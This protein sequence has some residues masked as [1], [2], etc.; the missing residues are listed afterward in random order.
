MAK[1]QHGELILL[2]FDEYSHPNHPEYI[3]GEVTLEEAQKAVSGNFG[4]DKV[5]TEI[6]HKYAFWGV[7]QNEMGEPCQ[8]LYDRDEPGRGRFKVTECTC[9]WAAGERDGGEK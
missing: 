7:G 9:R 1:Y 8:V 3:K 5:V 4:D 2:N 6:A